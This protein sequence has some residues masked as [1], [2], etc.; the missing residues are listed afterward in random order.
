MPRKLK[1]IK[2]PR[3]IRGR[4]QM[5]SAVRTICYEYNMFHAAAMIAQNESGSTPISLAKRYTALESM[6]LHARILRDFFTGLNVK[7]EDITLYDFIQHAPRFKL[8]HLRSKS[9][10]GRMNKMLA[11][12]SFS[13][14]R[15]PKPW[16]TGLLYKE[17]S[18]AWSIL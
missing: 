13:R 7:D 6:L 18:T 3:P 15:Y 5:R 9:I 8:S 1:R 17:V 2:L 12:A 4:T 14:R 10:R 16:N 11:H